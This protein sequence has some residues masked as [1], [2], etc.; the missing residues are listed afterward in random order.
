[1]ILLSFQYYFCD[2]KAWAA[3]RKKAGRSLNL[4]ST[5]SGALGTSQKNGGTP[6]SQKKTLV[7]GTLVTKRT[8]G[9]RVGLYRIDIV[10][11]HKRLPPH[12]ISMYSWVIE[13]SVFKTTWAGTAFCEVFHWFLSQTRSYLEASGCEELPLHK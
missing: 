5:M 1:M 2:G 11:P 6:S 8:C 4:R 12:R 10:I 13:F 3:S 7:M 9:S